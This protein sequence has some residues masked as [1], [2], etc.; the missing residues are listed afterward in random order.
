MINPGLLRAIDDKELE[1]VRS[2]RNAPSVRGNMY[3]RHEITAAEHQAWWLRTKNNDSA[4]Y[5][6]YEM[7]GNPTGVVAFTSIDKNSR[8]SCWAFYASPD[9]SSGTGSRMEFLAL[10]YAFGELALHK[11]Y[12][13]VLG[14]NKRV[15]NLHHKFGFQT[16]GV[17]REHHWVDSTFV[18]VHRLAIFDEEWKANREAMSAR[19]QSRIRG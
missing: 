13:E 16:E 18:D 2:W 5:F 8:N 6:M 10:D 14:Y 19:L 3:T 15:I 4:R 17:F 11:L 12:C 7:D 9:A 1:L